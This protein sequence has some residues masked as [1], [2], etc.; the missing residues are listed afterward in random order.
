[1]R[2]S[3]GKG[4]LQVMAMINALAAGYLYLGYL[5]ISNDGTS[6]YRQNVGGKS[7]SQSPHAPLIAKSVVL[8]RP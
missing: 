2:E 3:N 1:M 8:S 4:D 6:G 7:T 5:L